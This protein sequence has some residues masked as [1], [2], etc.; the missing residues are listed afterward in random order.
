[1]QEAINRAGISIKYAAIKSGMSRQALSN[2]IANRT[3]VTPHTA[4][5]LYRSLGLDPEKVLA[6]QARYQL[7]ALGWKRDVR[8]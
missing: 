1:M 4:I 5:K 6:F 3:T 8:I 2:V 7:K